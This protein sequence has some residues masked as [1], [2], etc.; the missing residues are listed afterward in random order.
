MCVCVYSGCSVACV[1]A[2][3]GEGAL[4][5]PCS[6]PLAPWINADCLGM[7]RSFR[8]HKESEGGGNA[9]LRGGCRGGKRR[10]VHREF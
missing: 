7:T 5:A 2:G 9:D 3:Q 10:G 1:S 4:A 8:P 6:R